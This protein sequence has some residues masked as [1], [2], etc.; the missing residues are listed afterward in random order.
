MVCACDNVINLT[1]KSN[2]CIQ[3]IIGPNMFY[4]YELL[5][6]YLKKKKYI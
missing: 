6:M 3:L 2:I 1:Y 4:E 5:K